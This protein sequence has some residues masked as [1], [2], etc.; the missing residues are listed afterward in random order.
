MNCD[1]FHLDNL[2]A[3]A[4]VTIHPS[5]V[6]MEILSIPIPI[7]DDDVGLQDNV[8]AILTIESASS[9]MVIITEPSTATITITNEDRE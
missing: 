8:T 6:M 4:T 2:F 3:S 1:F 9:D 5:S 7:P